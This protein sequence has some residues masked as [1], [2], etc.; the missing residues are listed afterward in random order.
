MC[1]EFIH[2]FPNFSGCTVHFWKWKLNFISHFT[3]HVMCVSANRHVTQLILLLPLSC[4]IE[5]CCIVVLDS[6]ITQ[7]HNAFSRKTETMVMR[8]CTFYYISNLHA[9]VLSSK[10]LPFTD[11][12]SNKCNSSMTNNMFQIKGLRCSGIWYMY[13]GNIKCI[14]YIVLIYLTHTWY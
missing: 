13:V 8:Q 10:H 11:K 4:H 14:F 6:V 3:G 7:V 5:N 1:D 9:S 2:P 12:K